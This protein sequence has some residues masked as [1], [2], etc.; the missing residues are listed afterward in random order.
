MKIGLT[1]IFPG[2]LGTFVVAGFDPLGWWVIALFGY[3]GLLLLVSNSRTAWQAGLMGLIFGI[4][5][6]LFGSGWVFG[7]LHNKVGMG[8]GPSV[9]STLIFVVYLALFTAVPCLFWRV[10]FKLKGESAWVECNSALL[11]TVVFSALLTLGE[12]A[13]SL[14][15][16][17]FT[18]LS[19]GYSLIDTWLAGFVPVFGVYGLSW[20]G[21]C[22]SGMLVVLLT[23]RFSIKVASL[24]AIIAISIVGLALGQQVWTQASGAPL[25]FRL[26][27]S[28]VTQ[29]RKFDPSYM[30]QQTERLVEAI[31]R[32]PADLVVTP[33]TA[34]PMFLN[35]VPDGVL[36]SLQQFTLRTASHVFLGVATIATN[37]DG[38]N[39][40]LHFAPG[41]QGIARYN[42][43]QLMPF[44]EYSPT[45]FGWFTGSLNIPLKDMS[46]GAHDQAPF[47]IGTQR[48]GTLICHEDLT[49]QGVRRWLP[50][51]TL[52]LN[53]SNLAWFEGSLAIGQRL[54]IVRMRALES[55]RPILRV[56]NT[57]ITAQIDAHGRVLGLLPASVEGVLSGMIQPQQGLTPYVRWGDWPVALA[58]AMCALLAA[59][60]QLRHRMVNVLDE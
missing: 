47:A 20:I 9:F 3:A 40:M 41:Q 37:S 34:F 57:G 33:E 60:I 55:G 13:R 22:I 5:L 4:G 50:S 51:A 11:V 25:S 8:V 16:N 39:S 15:F 21:F 28:N 6:H 17:G 42:K 24:I 44:G 29:E 56:T 48:A 7:A 18:S 12:W 10:L 45:G 53:P 30:R 26:I 35:E 58:G 36:S 31:E 49:S 27:Q 52:L 14:F 23:A 2:L 54:Q 19:L 32:Q 43:V 46:P 1:I 38:H 59:Y